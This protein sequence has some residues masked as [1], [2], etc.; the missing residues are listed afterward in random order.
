MINVTEE[1][2]IGVLRDSLAWAYVYGDVIPAHQW[3][4]MREDKVS[5]YLQKL[6]EGN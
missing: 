2:L 4:E 3:D 5:Q 6:K 1:Q